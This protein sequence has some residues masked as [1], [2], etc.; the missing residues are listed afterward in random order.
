[1]NRRSFLL[2][3]TATGAAA[4]GVFYFDLNLKDATSELQQEGEL[5]ETKSINDLEITPTKAMQL[6]SLEVERSRQRSELEAPS[7]GV[8]TFVWIEIENTG[9]E[10]T[11]APA[12]N[13]SNYDTMTKSDDEIYLNGINDI[14]L[15]TTDDCGA[16]PPKSGFDD[17][18][19]S[20]F[21]HDSAK[22]DTYG[23]HVNDGPQLAPD[24]SVSGWAFA[25]TNDKENTRLKINHQDTGR[26]WRVREYTDPPTPED[27]MTATPSGGDIE[28]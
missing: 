13:F 7:S 19:A 8:F 27:T 1:M 25:V 15:C 21:Y 12:L 18:A 9:L 23:P 20:T 16:P 4:G 14:Q 3:A 5:G 10:E 24:A 22:L 6:S 28:L 26:T 17:H 11:T 2:G